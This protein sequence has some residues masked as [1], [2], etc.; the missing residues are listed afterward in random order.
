MTFSCLNALASTKTG[1]FA[2]PFE[3]PG[4]ARSSPTAWPHPVLACGRRCLN[5][6]LRSDMSAAI[7]ALIVFVVVAGVAFTLVSLVDQRNARARLLKDR[8]A[9]ERK[10]PERAP[11]DELALL[12][13]EQL[14]EIPVFDSLLRRS[15][16]ISELQEMLAQGGANLRAG[17][18]LVVSVL[19]GV[20]ACLVSYILSKRPEVAG[21]ALL[22]GFVLPYSYAA[23]QRNR[24]FDKFEELFPE[25]IDTL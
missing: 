23:V 25:A 17:N 2:G 4:L 16:R 13:D 11:E 7:A 10:A 5:R 8:L 22:I 15:A 19:A 14:S 21:V 20:A 1:R 18:L 6:S 12:R 24:R 3:P 9:D